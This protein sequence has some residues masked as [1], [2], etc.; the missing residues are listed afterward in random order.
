MFSLKNT[1][2]VGVKHLTNAVLVGP[3]FVF[4]PAYNMAFMQLFER[5]KTP[6]EL[7]HSFK[8]VTKLKGHLKSRARK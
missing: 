6:G 1:L 7:D 2:K 5:N 8:R 3:M 4:A